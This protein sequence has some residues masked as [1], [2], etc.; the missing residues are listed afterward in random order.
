MVPHKTRLITTHPQSG[1]EEFVIISLNQS[2]MGSS[3]IFVSRQQ[4]MTRR[5]KL[6]VFFSTYKQKV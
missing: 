4:P 5:F 6:L 1:M 3:Q 2:I